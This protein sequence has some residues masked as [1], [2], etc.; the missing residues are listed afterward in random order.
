MRLLAV[1]E[2]GSERKTNTRE[3]SRAGGSPRIIGK[4]M[5]AVRTTQHIFPVPCS[6]DPVH[7]IRQSVLRH[8]LP[9]V[10]RP[11]FPLPR[12]L[13]PT[14]ALPIHLRNLP[15]SRTR[16][17]FLL[18]RR[19]L[20]I[21]G[22]FRALC[23]FRLHQKVANS[24]YRR[25]RVVRRRSELLRP[26]CSARGVRLG[27]TFALTVVARGTQLRNPKE[28]T[29]ARRSRCLEIPRPSSLQK[30]NR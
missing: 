9:D 5:F 19:G 11:V 4:A 10:R 21:D 26:G 17:R 20:L 16:F 12:G 18:F 24:R 1:R 3:E 8:L 30:K 2:E 22:E 29:P 15:L 14:A 23:R 27:R 25:H 6:L 7:G 28:N 13:V